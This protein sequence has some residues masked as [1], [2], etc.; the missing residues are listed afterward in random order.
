M[1]ARPTRSALLLALRI[2]ATVLMSL[3]IGQAGLAAGFLTSQPPLRSVHEINAY[4]L[5]TTTVAILITAI[6]YQRGGGPRWAVL[7]GV[8]LL[9]VETLQIVFARLGATGPHIFLG[10]LFVVMATLLTSYLFRPG[11]VPRSG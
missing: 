5:V 11:F 9:V 2:E 6:G 7:A 1:A 8:I 4:L 3:A 10:V